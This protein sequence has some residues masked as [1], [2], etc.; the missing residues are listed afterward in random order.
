[1]N[2]TFVLTQ[3]VRE[4]DGE[5]FLHGE[6]CGFVSYSEP[7]VVL[8]NICKARAV[9]RGVGRAR[10]LQRRLKLLPK[11]NLTQKESINE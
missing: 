5:I 7:L 3:H 6:E 8:E 11:P 10:A 1:M 4:P 9:T 2:I